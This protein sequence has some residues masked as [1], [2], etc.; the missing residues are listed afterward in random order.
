[1]NWNELLV[2]PRN[3]GVPLGASKT[4]SEPKVC[5]TQAVHL[6]CT[7]TNIINKRIG[8]RFHMTTVTWEF[9]RVCPKWFLSLWYVRRK[10]CTYIVSRL[11]LSLNP[12]KQ[13]SSCASSPRCTIG[14]VQNDFWALGT[15]GANCARRS[16]IRSSKMISEPMIRSAQTVQLSCVKI[17]TISKQ[18]IT[19]FPLS[20][21][22]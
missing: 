13:A 8:T 20:H 3:L 4:I 21:I 2:E 10:P 22:S 7:D 17:R 9:H 15:F 12:P 16:S 1:M 18:T 11:A 6:S 19:S 5:L 14:F